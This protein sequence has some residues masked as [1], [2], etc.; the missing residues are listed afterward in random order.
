MDIAIKIS[1]YGEPLD[2]FTISELHGISEFK[3]E[4]D[5]SYKTFVHQKTDGFGSG[6]YELA[7]ELLSDISLKEFIEF[8]VG[9][10]AYDLIKSGS[11]RLILKPFY[12]AYSKLKEK[13]SNVDISRLDFSFNDSTISIYKIFKNSI[14]EELENI[15]L[16]L[17][18][19][20]NN[21]YLQGVEKPYQIDIPIFKNPNG[22]H[23][24]DYRCK[25]SFD[26][27]I[28]E[29]G[30]ED[31]YKFWGSFYQFKGRFYVYD[32]KNQVL[33]T[34]EYFTEELYWEKVQT[35]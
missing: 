20:Y 35:M 7:I 12:A 32:Y 16:G 10:V 30:K 5:K 34:N 19:N 11:R 4:L 13:N 6:F 18:I 2:D 3:E 26:E 24:I 23:N 29:I 17:Q 14:F 21:L 9:G 25:L 1:Y 15:L 8:V 31:Y 22:T 27:T 28:K 33:T